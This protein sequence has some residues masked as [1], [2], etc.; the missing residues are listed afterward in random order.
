MEFFHKFGKITTKSIIMSSQ[1]IPLYQKVSE[2]IIRHSLDNS[3]TAV[4][5]LQQKLAEKGFRF[6]RNQ[7]LNNYTFDF[8][9]PI[10]K[11]AIEIDS[12]AHEFSDIHNLDAPKKLYISSLGIT[13]LRFTDYQIL[14][15]IEEISRT[16]K[17]LISTSNERIYVV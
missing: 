9:C 1:S 17:S 15:D 11:I 8:Y 2:K 3:I 6:L 4:D 14:T 12:Y 13:V 16:V 7:N 10:L 5:Q